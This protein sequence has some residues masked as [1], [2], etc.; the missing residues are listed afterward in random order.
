[1]VTIQRELVRQLNASGYRGP[2]TVLSRPVS[3]YWEH[4]RTNGPT[5]S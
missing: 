3:V 1:M 2:L 5:K 4:F